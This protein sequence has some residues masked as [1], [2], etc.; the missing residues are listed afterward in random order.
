METRSTPA[1]VP[2]S[3]TARKAAK[4]PSSTPE[5]MDSRIRPSTDSAPRYSALSRAA[6]ARPGTYWC[7]RSETRVGSGPRAVRRAQTPSSVPK[8]SGQITRPG[9]IAQKCRRTA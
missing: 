5:P 3:S 7:T 4:E 9:L 8:T 6:G 2:I 1:K